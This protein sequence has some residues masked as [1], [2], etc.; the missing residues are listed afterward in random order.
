[1]I[2]GWWLGKIE[3]SFSR[4][5]DNFLNYLLIKAFLPFI[6]L[7]SKENLCYRHSARFLK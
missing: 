6:L 3:I 4:N 1:M 5:L 7:L 2:S